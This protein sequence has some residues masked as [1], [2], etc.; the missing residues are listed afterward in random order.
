MLLFNDYNL[1]NNIN[2]VTQFKIIIINISYLMKVQF[3][4]NLVQI[5]MLSDI[6]VVESVIYIIEVCFLD[7]TPSLMLFL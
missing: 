7:S 2:F 5:I 3:S 6:V 1:K 4:I